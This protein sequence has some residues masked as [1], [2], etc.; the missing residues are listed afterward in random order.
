M[1]DGLH[2]TV[3][4]WVVRQRGGVTILLTNHALPQHSIRR[5]RVRITLRNSARPRSASIRRIDEGHANARR[6][7]Q[8][9]GEPEYLS[10]R[11]VE[12]LESASRIREDRC[13]WKYANRTASSR[14][15]SA[16]SRRG[17]RRGDVSVRMRKARTT[18]V[19]PRTL[20][21]KDLHALERKT[22][23]YFWSETNPQN[24][25]LPDNTLGNVPASIAGVGM[26]LAA[27][28]VG[29]ERR[30]TSRRAAIER[31][32]TT[33]RFFHE[34]EQ[35]P[36]PAATGYR[37]FYYHFLDVR[38]GRRAWNCELS[39]IDTAIL[40][41]G[42][43]TSA[44]YFDGT[45]SEERELRRLAK[46][47]YDRVD[48]QWAQNRGATVTHGW[49]PERGFLPY[50]WQ[51]YNEA[52]LLYVLGL[53]SETHPL[54]KTSYSA[55]TKTYV[56]KR[57]YGHEFR[58]RRSAVHAPAVA[59]L[60]RFSWYP[61]RLHAT[62]RHRLLREQPAR[63]LRAAAICDSQSQRVC[64]VRRIRLGH[65]GQQRPWAGGASNRRD[66]APFPGISRSRRALRS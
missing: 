28:P 23:R 19:A 46:A 3:D 1:V 54:P 37:G 24:G 20:T 47:L 45:S 32:L 63:D 33:L 64:R 25:L 53:G 49:K 13:A 27:Y 17:I 36:D 50:R 62:P 55:W 39:T 15:R 21:E 58:L 43:L 57:L 14:S 66:H 10:S 60:D 48:W 65:N 31:V 18:R 59:C 12:R 56:W 8:K 30:F 26:A 34:S 2:H 16:R 51:G 40:L 41:A 5:E 35:G 22:F 7:W 11:M 44:A 9:L 38:T 42:A 61:G 4:A 29:V 52:L 6:A